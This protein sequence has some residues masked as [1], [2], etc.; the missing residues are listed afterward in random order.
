MNN[1]KFIVNFEIFYFLN[2]DLRQFKKVDIFQVFVLC[3]RDP[4]NIQVRPTQEKC[5]PSVHPPILWAWEL[6]V[7]Q[8]RAL[9]LL[10]P[11]SPA[12]VIQRRELLLCQM[13]DMKMGRHLSTTPL[14]LLSVRVPGALRTRLGTLVMKEKDFILYIITKCPWWPGDKGYSHVSQ[15]LPENQHPW[16]TAVVRSGGGGLRAL[17]SPLTPGNWLYQTCPYLAL[18]VFR[19]HPC[20]SRDPTVVST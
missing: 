11:I 13:G 2:F 10:S 6:D 16:V 9:P 15:P 5:H 7:R 3:W 14:T 8:R 19:A 20:P 4:I 1:F 18:I 12:C 17:S